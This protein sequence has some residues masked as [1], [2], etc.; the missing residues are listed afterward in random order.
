[1]MFGYQM[2][3]IY[4][5]TVHVMSD[6]LEGHKIM[7]KPL[8]SKTFGKTI[9]QLKIKNQ[10]VKIKIRGHLHYFMTSQFKLKCLVERS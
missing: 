9:L 7:E 4:F 2:K 6:K 3:K 1:M 8:C 10:S 5:Y